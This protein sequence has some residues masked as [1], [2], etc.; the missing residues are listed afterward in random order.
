MSFTRLGITLCRAAVDRA[1]GNDRG[2][3]RIDEAG[4]DLLHRNDKLRGDVNGIDRGVRCG[5][6]S[7]FAFDR[8][9]QRV[10]RCVHR[11]RAKAE[12]PRGMTRAEMQS[13]RALDAEALEHAVLDHRLRAALAFF[14]GLKQEDNGARNL[15][16][17]RHHDLGRTEQNRNVSVVSAGMHHA[18]RCG[19]VG[20]VVF[21][22]DRQRV[23][24]GA[25]HDRVTR[26][27]AAHDADNAGFADPGM[28]FTAE[29]AQA[30]GDHRCRAM[31]V[32]PEL[33]VHMQVTPRRN[34][35]RHHL[36]Y[37]HPATGTG[38]GFG[39]PVIAMPA[40]SSAMR[41]DEPRGAIWV[42]CVRIAARR[43]WLCTMRLT[44]ETTSAVL[45]A[46]T[47][48]PFVRT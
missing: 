8:D 22:F 47:P 27:L 3:E 42:C 25:Q 4:D 1:D 14:G 13:V 45:S 20:D 11:P 10:A 35:A 37:C 15:G 21:L 9:F 48:M 40:I 46:T 44:D 23:H 5:C 17:S 26:S 32:K 28:H 19:L 38:S 12:L 29:I 41:R 2:L 18:R 24:I 7:A 30:V 43:S 36:R 16:A 34:D 33:R 6:V 39:R 31:L